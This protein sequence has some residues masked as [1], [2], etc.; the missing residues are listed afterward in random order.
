[1]SKITLRGVGPVV[2]NVPM[3]DIEAVIDTGGLFIQCPQC[4]KSR[5]VEPTGLIIVLQGVARDTTWEL[6]HCANT[7]CLGDNEANGYF[8]VASTGGRE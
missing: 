2:E 1:M 6:H 5:L 8:F 7:D 4:G 3:Y